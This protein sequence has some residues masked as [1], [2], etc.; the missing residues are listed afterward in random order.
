MGPLIVDHGEYEQKPTF[1]RPFALTLD[2]SKAQEEGFVFKP[3]DQWFPNLVK[4][5]AD[6]LGRGCG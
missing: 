1:V 3:F 6:M 4:D 2:I 5:T